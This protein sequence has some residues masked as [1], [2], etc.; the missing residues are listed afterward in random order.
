MSRK[1]AEHS[2]KKGVVITD[3]ER[4]R[5][6]RLRE[7]LV[8][9]SYAEVKAALTATKPCGL[10]LNGEP[11]KKNQEGNC[12]MCNGSGIIRD[13]EQ[14]KWAAELVISRADPAPKSVEMK[15]DD[16]RDK[17]KLAE[18]YAN[19]SKEEVDRLLETLNVTVQGENADGTSPK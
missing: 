15:I 1:A 19:L 10:C 14:R 8:E 12:L 18:K 7:G 6:K 3:Q 16:N 17:E 5:A 2:E 11:K 9:P 13:H 4:D